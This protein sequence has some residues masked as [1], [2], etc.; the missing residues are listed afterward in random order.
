VAA[1]AKTAR[2]AQATAENRRRSLV[3]AAAARN[4]NGANRRMFAAKSTRERGA[5][6]AV[7]AVAIVR[8][9]SVD[10]R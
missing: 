4:P 7:H 9:I 6:P 1:A 5:T 8:P 10:V 3:I 2:A